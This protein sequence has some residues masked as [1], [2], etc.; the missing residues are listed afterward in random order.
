MQISLL[1]F[2]N[3]EIKTFY[4]TTKDGSKYIGAGGDNALVLYRMDLC[5]V[6]GHFF[7]HILY[8]R[9]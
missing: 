7:L 3:D 9:I 4:G 6:L 1:G 8:F 5:Q 2:S